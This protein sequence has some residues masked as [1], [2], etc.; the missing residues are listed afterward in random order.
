MH[1]LRPWT[2]TKETFNKYSCFFFLKRKKNVRKKLIR[3]L[4]EWIRIGF[5]MRRMCQL[6]KL[7]LKLHTYTLNE[8]IS[9][10]ICCFE[11]WR[12]NVTNISYIYIYSSW[13]HSHDNVRRL[14]AFEMKTFLLGLAV[15]L[16]YSHVIRYTAPSHLES[17]NRCHV[18]KKNI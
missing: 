5:G 8:H 18:A 13:S 11:L 1:I 17:H 2:W 12:G 16:G 3:I 10:H 15:G 7:K 9:F 6:P 4:C 14:A